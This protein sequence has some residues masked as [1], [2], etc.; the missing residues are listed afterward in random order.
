MAEEYRFKRQMVPANYVIFDE[1]Q[2]GDAA[3]MIVQGEVD[4]RIGMTEENPQ[5]LGTRGK[6]PPWQH[7][8]GPCRGSLS[9]LRD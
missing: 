8:A 2:A 9:V 1:G 6:G 3:Y 4:I 7:Q 5:S